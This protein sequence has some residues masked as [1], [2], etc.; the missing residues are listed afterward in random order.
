MDPAKLLTTGLLSYEDGCPPGSHDPAARLAVLDDEGIDVALLYPTIGICWEGHVRDAALAHAYT[1]A[2]NRWLVDFCSHDFKRLVPIMHLNLLDVGLAVAEMRRAHAAGC[3]GIYIS[4]DMYARDR[5]RF[6]DAALA[7]FWATAE[8]L[9]L[10]VAFHVVVRDQP[11]TSYADPLDDA[12][13]ERFGLFNF[14]FLAIDVM[15]AFTELLTTGVLERHPRL[16]VTVLESGANWISAWLDRLITGVR[17]DA[18]THVLEHEA[19]RSI[20]NGSASVSADPTRP[21]LPR[22]C[23]TSARNTSCGRRTIR[24]STPRWAWCARCV[25][26]WRRCRQLISAWCWARTPRG[27]TACHAEP[28]GA[29]SCPQCAARAPSLQCRLHGLAR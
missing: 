16:K 26:A 14:A 29:N 9:E 25:S 22:W 1:E 8:E 17:G 21:S 27:S 13:G 28:V 19:Q 4:P 18:L 5:R 23:A 6:D 10:P 24:T 2:Y 20:S 11:T 15:A 7:P 12:N 3:R